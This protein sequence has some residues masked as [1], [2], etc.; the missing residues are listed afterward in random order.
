MRSVLTKPMRVSACAI[1]AGACGISTSAANRN[2]RR[3][4]M[5]VPLRSE[6]GTELQL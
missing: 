6:S 1:A 4:C 2:A 5:M 3:N